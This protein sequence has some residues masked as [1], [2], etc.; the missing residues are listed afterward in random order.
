MIH[1]AETY[2]R[3]KHAG[4]IYEGHGDYADTH[5]SAVVRVL[6]EC[7]FDHPQWQAA[8]WLHDVI[9][10]TDADYHEVTLTFGSTIGAL[11]FAVTGEGA[12]R[13]ERNASIYRKIDA[14]PKAAI[15]KCADRIANVEAAQG[16]RFLEKYRAEMPDFERHIRP[17]VPE[18][19]WGRLTRAAFGDD[20]QKENADG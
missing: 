8:G 15:L 5:L 11:V 14:L 4:Q 18:A 17:H 6:G 3:E 7:G 12:N 16:T 2:A 9:E 10:D 1:A 20:F 13:A 19:M